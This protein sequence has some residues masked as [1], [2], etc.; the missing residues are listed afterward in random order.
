MIVDRMG[1]III[2]YLHR[3]GFSSFGCSQTKTGET[4]QF[5]SPAIF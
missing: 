1:I 4:E 3:L 5:E 2:N